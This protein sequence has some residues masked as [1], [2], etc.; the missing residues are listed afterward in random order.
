MALKR[1]GGEAK[2]RI[3]DDFIEAKETF[4]NKDNSVDIRIEALHYMISHKEIHYVLQILAENFKENRVEDHPFI[5]YAFSSFRDKPRRD[6]DF[7]MLFKMLKSDNAYL[8]N[9]V[10]VF[11]QDYG[12]EAKPFFE[13]L[14]NS[15]DAD[16]RIFAINIL[17][18]V[19]FEDS[20]DMLRYFILKETEINPLMTAIDYLGEIG[21]KSDIVILESLKEQFKDNDYVK[22]GIDL[23]IDR[24]K[25]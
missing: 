5:D 17:G 6:K 4:E 21:D 12:I 10:I 22:F 7:E 19:R 2:V 16:I 1:S 14:M 15:E 20:V 23:A 11:L 8:R 9:A 25:G 18:D 24:I 13:E 3:F